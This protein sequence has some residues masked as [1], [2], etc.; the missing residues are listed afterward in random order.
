MLPI[1]RMASAVNKDTV[2][3]KNG[4]LV[5]YSGSTAQVQIDG[6]VLNL[7]VLDSVGTSLPVGTTVVCQVHGM[8]GYVIG[9][10]NTVSRATSGTWTGSVYNPPVPRP[11]TAGINYTTFA[12]ASFGVYENLYGT[13]ITSAKLIQSNS[14]FVTVPNL[15]SGNAAIKSGWFYGS[16]AFTGLTGKTI[17]TVEIFIPNLTDSTDAYPLNFQYHTLATAASSFAGLTLTGTA[18]TVSAGG[19]VSLSTTFVAGLSANLTAFGVG[20]SGTPQATLSGTSPFG[21]LRI[22]WSN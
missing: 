21:T 15:G 1:A 5:Y 16:N 9:S 4:I 2:K 8:T 17:K 13:K 18:Q 19:W 14:Y 3:V 7:Q 10:L 6:N 11:N 20:I 12:P 22:G